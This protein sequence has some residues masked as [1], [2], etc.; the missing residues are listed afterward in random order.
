M[1]LWGPKQCIKLY[2]D[3]VAPHGAQA[4]GVVRVPSAA[5][6]GAQVA[7]SGIPSHLRCTGGTCQRA[8]LLCIRT[9]L[10]WYD[11]G[12]TMACNAA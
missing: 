12:M 8:V 3:V 7:R 10:Q 6:Q 1:W 9:A 2:L 5:P 11:H 4:A